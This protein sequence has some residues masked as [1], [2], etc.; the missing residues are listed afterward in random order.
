MIIGIICNGIRHQSSQF[1]CEMGNN[2]LDLLKTG[3]GLKVLLKAQSQ[4]K[5]NIDSNKHIVRQT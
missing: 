4:E 3:R 1:V 5:G 2:H